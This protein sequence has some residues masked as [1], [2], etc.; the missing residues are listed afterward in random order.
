MP[1]EHPLFSEET[2]P[3]TICSQALLSPKGHSVIKYF[4]NQVCPN[5]KTANIVGE[6]EY[7]CYIIALKINEINRHS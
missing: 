4:L 5:L 7:L 1:L 3:L 6:N 2:P